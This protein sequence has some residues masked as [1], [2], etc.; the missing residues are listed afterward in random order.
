MQEVVSRD[1]QVVIH[2]ST[3]IDIVASQEMDPWSLVRNRHQ[4]H[5]TSP[6]DYKGRAKVILLLRFS[7]LIIH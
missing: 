3:F 1:N 7:V 6:Y 5:R 2:E 4:R